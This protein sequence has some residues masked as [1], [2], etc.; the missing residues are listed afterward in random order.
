MSLRF[1]LLGL[2]GLTSFAGVACAALVQP[3]P[4]WTSII[5]TLTAA[6][7][8]WQ[9]LRVVLLAGESR[10]AAI[11]WLLF[12]GGYLALVLAPWLGERVGPQLLSS[13]ALAHAQTHWRKDG[14]HAAISDYQRMSVDLYGVWAANPTANVWIDPGPQPTSWNLSNLTLAPADSAT[15]FQLAGHWLCAWLAGWL[16]AVAAVQ[17]RRRQQHAAPSA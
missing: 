2:I 15:H 10:A 4:G 14:P 3:G 6:V 11:G 17:C 8:A 5:V 7:F 13:K 9:I 16:G 1:S 12:A